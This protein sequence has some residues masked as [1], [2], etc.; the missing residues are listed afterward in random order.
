MAVLCRST[1][2]FPIWSK[3][4]SVSESHKTGCS[5]V[6]YMLIV[7]CPQWERTIEKR[8]I[9]GSCDWNS[10][11][12]LEFLCP[13]LRVHCLMSI[14]FV[15]AATSFDWNVYE[16]YYYWDITNTKLTQILGV[17]V[18]SHFFLLTL[19]IYLFGACCVGRVRSA[20]VFLLIFIKIMN[21]SISH[22]IRFKLLFVCWI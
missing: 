4:L 5:S 7:L 6:I 20:F 3:S 19:K 11:R 2:H 17:C 22:Q 14:F 12:W 8:S 16:L 18:F 21:Y 9:Y 1:N 10:G 15:G 13:S